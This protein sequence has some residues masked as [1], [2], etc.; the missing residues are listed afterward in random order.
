MLIIERTKSGE[1]YIRVSLVSFAVRK[2]IPVQLG[3]NPVTEFQLR[4]HLTS[5]PIRKIK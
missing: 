3:V 2:Y 5:V 4:G 1:F